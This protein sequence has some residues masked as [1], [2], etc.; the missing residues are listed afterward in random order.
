MYEYQQYPNLMSTTDK[1]SYHLTDVIN[2]DD[3]D[4]NNVNKHDASENNEAEHLLKHD[5]TITAH[6]V[7]DSKSKQEITE[8]LQPVI[9]GIK[10]GINDSS[11][12]YRSQLHAKRS[13]I[14]LHKEI[15]HYNLCLI[16][17]YGNKYIKLPLQDN[18]SILP[19]VLFGH[20]DY[21]YM[22]KQN[23]VIIV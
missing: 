7:I 13:R 6:D 12:E 2:G 21:I 1:N 11:E 18:S 22:M 10:I 16:E 17:Q 23:I 9:L 8:S 4:I 3:F 19:M 15:S 20:L 14:L 5:I